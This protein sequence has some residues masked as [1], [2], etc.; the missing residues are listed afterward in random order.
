MNVSRTL[1]LVA[2]PAEEISAVLPETDMLGLPI[3]RRTVL[4]ARKAG[5]ERVLV[6][7]PAAAASLARVLEGTVAELAPFGFRP[8]EDATILPWNVVV[9]TRALRDLLSG[10]AS[11][12]S[13]V[14]LHSQADLS[15]AERWLLSRVVKDTDGFMARHVD[16]KISLALSRSLARTTITPNQVT[17]VSV[18]IGLAGAPFFLSPRPALQVVGAMLFVL[19]SIVDGCDGELARL[20]LQES[21]WGGV[22]DFWG[23]NVVHCAVFAAIAVGWSLSEGAR[24]PLIF[25]VAAVTGTLASAGFAYLATMRGPREGPLFTA[26]T[27]SEAPAS[28]I[29]NAL[30]RRDF[31]YLVLALSL[32]G[33]ANWFL[34]L[35]AVGAPLFFLVLVALGAGRGAT[36]SF[37]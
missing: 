15:R 2:P 10:R 1:A 36:R 29:V 14:P 3:I 5:F 9:D 20:R 31:I 18:A 13:G 22:L 16:R 24:W 33:K 4:A 11:S 8:P 19:H 7:A 21:R 34:V 23:D 37:S 35:A 25:G 30:A 17:L 26:V 27:N 28:K 12:E 6:L 32:F